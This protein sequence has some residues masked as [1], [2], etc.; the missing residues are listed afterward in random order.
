[1]SENTFISI[2]INQNSSQLLDIYTPLS[3]RVSDITITLNG[4]IRQRNTLTIMQWLHYLFGV[5]EM[6]SIDFSFTPL[7]NITSLTHNAC[8]MSNIMHNCQCNFITDFHQ[9]PLEPIYR[10]IKWVEIQ[11]GYFVHMHSSTTE[12]IIIYQTTSFFLK[13][14]LE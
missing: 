6:D 10:M 8:Q 2:N 3:L 14:P 13:W 12:C 5:I 4:N 1:M 7:S 11:G 9:H